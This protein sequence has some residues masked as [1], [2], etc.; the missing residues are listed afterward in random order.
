[1]KP[2]GASRGIGRAIAVELDRSPTLVV[3]DERSPE[4]AAEVVTANTVASGKTWS[5]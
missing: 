1:V 2:A 5:L 4:A 3:N